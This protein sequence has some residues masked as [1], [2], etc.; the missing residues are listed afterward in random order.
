MTKAKVKQIDS[1]IYRRTDEGF[2]FLM[3]KRNAKKH[4]GNLWQGVAGKI[5]KGETAVETVLRE[6]KE[7]TG[8]KPIKLFVTDHVA[9]FYNAYKDQIFMVPV[10]GIEVDNEEVKLSDEHCEFRWV[11]FEK[12]LDL[13]TWKGQKE[14]IKTVH[15]MITRNDDR[16]KWAK[17]PLS[18]KEK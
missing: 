2:K 16:I 6:L 1:Y 14:A 10:F 4:Y 13:L 8:F 7:E 17:L 15:D 9:S 12:A 3:L 18:K 11:P 5:E